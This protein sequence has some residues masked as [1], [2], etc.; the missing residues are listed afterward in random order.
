MIREREMA[1]PD[2]I[3][4][5][6][7]GGFCEQPPLDLIRAVAR[8]CYVVDDDLLIGMRWILSDVPTSGDPLQRLADAYLEDSSYSPVQHDDRKKKEE[9]LLERIRLAGAEAAIVT[10][11]KM[12]EPA[13][14]EQVA[15]TRSLDEAEVPYF[16]SEFEENMTSFDHLEIQLETFVENLMFD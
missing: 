11:A 12:C 15:Y 14:E 2:R 9:M 13:L 5:V 4:V 10:A 7:E 8:S 16:V 3:R 1:R 6:Y